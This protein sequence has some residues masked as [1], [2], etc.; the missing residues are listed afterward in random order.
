MGDWVEFWWPVEITFYTKRLSRWFCSSWDLTMRSMSSSII[1][2]CGQVGFSEPVELS[3]VVAILHIG[4]FQLAMH[5]QGK[6]PYENPWGDLQEIIAKIDAWPQFILRLFPY[7]I[8][9][10]YRVQ[11]EISRGLF[12]RLLI[13]PGCVCAYRVPFSAG[14]VLFFASRVLFPIGRVLF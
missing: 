1:E 14:R 7:S 10:R 3:G 8:V 5:C 13:W 9:N 4:L 12:I 2:V 11:L 6:C